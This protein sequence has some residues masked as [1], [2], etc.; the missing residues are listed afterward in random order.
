MPSSSDLGATK[1]AS[2]KRKS[3]SIRFVYI[4]TYIH[5]VYSGE[6]MTGHMCAVYYC[7]HV[8]TRKHIRPI[9]ESKLTTF[10]SLLYGANSDREG[11]M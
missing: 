5:V 3:N 4:Y 6:Q 1:T 9:L 10:I 2:T 11:Y 8:G 7:V